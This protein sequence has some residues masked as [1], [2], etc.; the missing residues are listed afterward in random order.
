MYHYNSVKKGLTV[1]PNDVKPRSPSLRRRK[2]LTYRNVSLVRL[3]QAKPL[4]H[5]PF[6]V[7]GAEPR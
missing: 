1:L 5:I 6:P 4:R 7:C 2:P 3:P